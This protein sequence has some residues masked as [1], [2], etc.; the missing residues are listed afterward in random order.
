MT[1][2]RIGRV[3]KIV[4][5]E[6]SECYVGSTFNTTRDRLKNHKGDYLRF[7]NGKTHHTSV[8]DLFS[9]YGVDGCRMV[10]IKEYEVIDRRHLETKELLWM[11]KLKSINK[12]QP[13]D[14]GKRC[15]DVRCMKY[16]EEH[17]EERRTYAKEHGKKY[18]AEHKEEIKAYRDGRK[19]IRREYDKEYRTKN[20]ERCQARCRNYYNEHKEKIM[21]YQLEKI[22]CLDCGIKVCRY[23]IPRHNKTQKH[24]KNLALNKTD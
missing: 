16:R 22:D 4:A 8:M 2:Y 23:Y 1:E 14:G 17:V 21:E 19:D 13:F 11:K 12:I 6:G 7:K 3:Y 5:I 15:R 18:Y 10:L 9:K 20:A 24:L